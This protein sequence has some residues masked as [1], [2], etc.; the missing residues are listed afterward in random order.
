MY[1]VPIRLSAA[2]MLATLNLP[3]LTA[4]DGFRLL[5]DPQYDRFFRPTVKKLCAGPSGRWTPICSL[6]ER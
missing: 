5:K 3:R 1:A 4:R 6:V 2:A